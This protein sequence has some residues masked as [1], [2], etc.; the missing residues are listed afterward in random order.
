MYKL[1]LLTAILQLTS[2]AFA[3]KKPLREEAVKEHAE[4]VT[5]EAKIKDAKTGEVAPAKPSGAIEKTPEDKMVS[6]DGSQAA[7]PVP[8]LVKFSGFA[9]VELEDS[10]NFGYNGTSGVQNFDSAQPQAHQNFSSFLTNLQLDIAKDKTNFTTVLEVGEMIN[11]ETTTGGAQGG[12]Q[13]VMEIRNVYLTHEFSN[14][15]NVKAGLL[16]LASDPNSF[17][18]ADHFSGAVAE[19]KTASTTSTVW[20]AKAYEDKP[21]ATPTA[22]APKPDT[23]YGL[24]FQPQF[25]EASK[26]NAFVVLRRTNEQLYDPTSAGLVDGRSAYNWYGATYDLAMS[27]RYSAQ[28]TGILNASSFSGNTPGISDDVQSQLFDL[29]LKSTWKEQGFE[30][31]VE[32]LATSGATGGV[33]AAS[34]KAVIGGRKN[35]NSSPGVGYLFTI[36]TSDGADDAPGIAKESTIANLN[37]PEGLQVGMIKASQAF[38]DRFSG[39]LRAGTLRTATAS[40]LTGSSHLGDEVDVNLTYELS[41]GTQL[42]ADYGY[43]KPGNYFQLKDAAHLFATRL[44]F[45][46]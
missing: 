4:S 33:D 43:F 27:E 40:A 2:P 38:T 11:G 8:L 1:L 25:S 30:L 31:L 28:V 18:V 23:Y 34:T 21:A 29:K 15:W 45:A 5:E 7:I 24:S 36:A 3:K 42:Q 37:Q 39:F 35:F 10:K 13:K 22:N 9:W 41:P 20:T 6:A 17:V 26:L 32:G 16:P 44:K 19:Y 46:F 12:R 14:A